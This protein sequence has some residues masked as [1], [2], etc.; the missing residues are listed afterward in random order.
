MTTRFLGAASFILLGLFGVA[1]RPAVGQTLVPPGAGQPIVAPTP[2]EQSMQGV[3]APAAEPQRYDGVVPGPTGRNPLPAAPK[4][5]PHLVWT[6][7][8]MTPT[9][10]RVFLQTTAPVQFDLDEGRVAKSGK[11]TLAV[12]LAGCRIHMANNR[13]RIDTR[14]FATPVAGVSARQKGHDVEVRIAMR[15]VAAGVP[16]SEAG[17]DGTQFVVIDFPPGKATPEP[18]A[19]EDMAKASGVQVQDGSQEMGAE[20]S[21]ASGTRRGKKAPKSK[22]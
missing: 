13:R 17:P 18:S 3:P 20:D 1:S 7:F 9:G 21:D 2:L 12:R 19:L 8:Q 15:E 22:R 11:S 10:S 6:G 16:H 4:A 14:F 5:G